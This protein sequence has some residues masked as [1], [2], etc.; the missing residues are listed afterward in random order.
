MS[1]VSEETSKSF[2]SLRYWYLTY[3]L[4]TPRTSYLRRTKQLI[5]LV[6]NDVNNLT[7][8]LSCCNAVQSVSSK[9][10]RKALSHWDNDIWLIF[11]QLHI[12]KI[13]CVEAIN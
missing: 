4:T 5:K 6:Y 12:L 8:I 2:V 11:S 1:S 10:D 9:K 3:F 7:Q 13:I